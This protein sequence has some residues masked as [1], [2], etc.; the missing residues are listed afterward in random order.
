MNSPTIN[1]VV[2]RSEDP[3]NLAAFYEGLGMH[4][5]TERHGNGCEHLASTGSGAVFEIYPRRGDE[6]A[7]RGV[8]LGFCVQSIS[9]ILERLG[10]SARLLSDRKDPVGGRRCILRDP[11]GHK[12][13]LSQAVGE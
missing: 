5:E 13:E 3:A 6:P 1:L 12:I 11:E 8:R 4:F 2:L 10:P 9:E 7:S